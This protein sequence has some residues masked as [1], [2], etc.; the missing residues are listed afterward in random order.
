MKILAL[1]VLGLLGAPGYADETPGAAQDQVAA[2]RRPY[3]EYRWRIELMLGSWSGMWAFQYRAW[4]HSG[5]GIAL[6]GVEPRGARDD[7]T[8]TGDCLHNALALQGWTERTMRLMPAMAGLRFQA[9]PMWSEYLVDTGESVVASGTGV[10]AELA[11]YF[12][13]PFSSVLADRPKSAWWPH[14][15]LESSI[16]FV[17]DGRMKTRLDLDLDHDGMVDHTKGEVFR[18]SRWRRRTLLPVVLP[19]AGLVW[20][21]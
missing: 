12:I 2:I 17:W 16:L 10:M 9:G 4:L 6:V 7:D 21:F 15:V 1:V 19:R 8:G 14:L 11:G 18:D 13:L 5:I 3:D 20:I